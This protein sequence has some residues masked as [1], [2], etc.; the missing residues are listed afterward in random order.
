MPFTFTHPAIVLP[1]TFLPRKWY[2]LTGLVVGSLTPDFEYF[3]RMRIE[4]NYSHTLSGLFWFDLPLGIL[5]TFIFHNIVRDN[6]YDNLP[7]IFSSR[8]IKFKEFN[9]NNYFNKNWFVVVISVLI[10]ASSHI[11]WDSFT[12]DTGFFVQEISI[13]ASS[14]ELFGKRIP[15]LKI[16][17]HTSSLIGGG[18]IIF[19]LLKIP[20]NKN[21][22][23]QP[24]KK[25]WGILITLTLVI[26]GIRL[27]SGLDYRL[28]GH[29][30]V[31]AISAGLTSLILTSCIIKANLIYLKKTNH[32]YTKK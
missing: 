16:L 18:V 12:H 30:I 2:S 20:S 21:V 15:I 5:L 10:G 7:F 27:L 19:S 31:T 23:T 13:L 11:F 8:L 9:W 22:K 14:I 6:L 26:I 1:L 29:V 25:Y 3:L 24:H 4:S 32:T 17:Q 28:Y